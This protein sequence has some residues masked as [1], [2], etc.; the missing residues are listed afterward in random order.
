VGI[1]VLVLIVGGWYYTYQ[2]DPKQYD[3]NY[4]DQ[5]ARQIDWHISVSP[6]DAVNINV[7]Q[8]VCECNWIPNPSDTTYRGST[9]C[10]RRY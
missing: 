3:E 2:L 6:E 4:C 1:A 7:A 5:Y 8:T 10:F 9:Q